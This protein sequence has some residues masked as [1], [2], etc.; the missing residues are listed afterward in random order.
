MQPIREQSVA[1]AEESRLAIESA[2]Y[3]ACRRLMDSLLHDAR[4]PLNALAIN[5]EVVAERLKREPGAGAPPVSAKGLAS[6]RDQIF[7]VDDVLKQ[8]AEFMAPP[9]APAPAGLSE[10]VQRAVQLV[11][12]EA[13]RSQVRLRPLIEPGVEDPFEDPESSR[14]VALLAVLRGVLRAEAGTEVTVTLSDDAG[15]PSL[16]VIDGRAS[17]AEPLRDALPALEALALRCGGRVEARAGEFVVSVP[18][19]VRT[20]GH[21]RDQ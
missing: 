14:V 20:E 4:N 8:F 2:R 16:R 12:Y 21:H 19:S 11:A 1:G 9:A 5:L 6:M 13:R 10:I 15:G 18:G 7:R 3:Q 17:E